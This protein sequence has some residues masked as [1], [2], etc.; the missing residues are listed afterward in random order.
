MGGCDVLIGMDIICLGDLAITNHDG[1]TIMTFSIPSHKPLCFVER[2]EKLNEP[3]FKK[4]I[5]KK[6]PVNQP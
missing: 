2:A 6:I 3:L 4:G 1:K 5:L